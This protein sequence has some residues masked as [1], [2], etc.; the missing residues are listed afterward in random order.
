MSA[1]SIN[2]PTA[3]LVVVVIAGVACAKQQTGSGTVVS[4]QLPVTSFSKIQV[5]YAFQV[6]LSIGNPEAVTIRADDNLVD[7]L[8]VGVTDDTLRIG[9]KGGTSVSSATLQADVTASSLSA[10]ESSGGSAVTLLDPIRSQ[11]FA[12]TQSGGSRFD[13]T[14]AISA[15]SVQLSGASD[16]SLTGSASTLAVS[17]SGASQLHARDLSIG[18]LTIDLSGASHGE[19]NVTGTMS[20]SASGASNLTYEGSPAVTRKDVSGASQ[21]TAA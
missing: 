9:L 12:L 17:A 8:D 19:V 13:G 1:R 2:R 4:R 14:V 16:A 15:G 5:S 11:S 3:F 10:I 21:I 20:A 7:D 6:R 18:A